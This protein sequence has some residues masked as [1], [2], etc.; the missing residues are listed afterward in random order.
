MTK[1]AF[2]GIMAGLQDALAMAKGDKKAGK[3][4]R[5]TVH[6]ADVKTARK[7]VGLTRKEFASTFGLSA[8]TLRKWENG[9]RHPTGAARA[10]LTI[11]SREPDAVLRAIKK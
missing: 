11:I 6:P 3:L 2:E 4:I 10:L 8:A 9:E 5:I 1:K 7:Q